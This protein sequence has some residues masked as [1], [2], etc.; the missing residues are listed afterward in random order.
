MATD[1]HAPL[2]HGLFA[3]NP[4]RDPRFD[5]KDRWIECPNFP[6]DDPRHQLEFFQ[7]QMNEEVNSLEASARCLTD[8][9]TADWELRLQL[10]RQCADEVRHARMFRRILESRGGYVGQF[11][12]LNFQYRIITNC[13]SLVGRL[14]VQNRS[15]EAG[16]IDAIAYGINAARDC[17]DPEIA[18]MYEAQ[19]ADEVTHVRF[20]NEWIRK[21]IDQN[22]RSVLE[23]GMALNAASR[24]F[25]EVMGTEGTEG[26]SYPIDEAGRRDAG[27]TPDEIR[28]DA[29][30]HATRA[31]Q[32]AAGDPGRG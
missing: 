16:G 2:T 11:P 13:K 6:G 18:A 31:R 12:V 9:P 4:A 20:A 26:V 14:A 21:A 27:F 22:R 25:A 5:V 30:I 15:F 17:G 29:E 32:L 10:A 7:R 3:E 23:I 8:F 1:A 24:A 28:T 19:L